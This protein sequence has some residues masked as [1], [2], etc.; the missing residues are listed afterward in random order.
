MDGL[1]PFRGGHTGSA[2][3][4]WGVLAQ[5]PEEQEEPNAHRNRRTDHEKLDDRRHRR[6]WLPP[7]H[8]KRRLTRVPSVRL[9][10]LREEQR[11]ARGGLSNNQRLCSERQRRQTGTHFPARTITT[12]FPSFHLVVPA[13][14]PEL[15]TVEASASGT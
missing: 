4:A 12:V 6:A 9:Q 11:R 5:R 3:A 1:A 10:P 8:G 7:T 13:L 15:H 14:L 2:R